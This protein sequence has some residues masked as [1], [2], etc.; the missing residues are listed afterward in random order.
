MEAS[1]E[2]RGRRYLTR[3]LLQGCPA[4]L[5]IASLLGCGGVVGSGPS[6]PPPLTISVSPSSASILLGEAQLFTATLNNATTSGVTWSVNGIAGGNPAVGTIDATGLYTAP[7]A[8]LASGA[9]TVQAASVDDPSKTASASVKITSDVSVSISPATSSVE[10]GAS[11]AFS[12]TV[13]SMGK[14]NPSF[15]W[16]V[17]ET[18]CTG[19]SCGIVDANGTYTAPQILPAVTSITLTATSI[20]DP[21]K[22]AT[23]SINLTSS[24]TLNLS[25][26]LTVFTRTVVNY[27]AVVTPAAN[28][29]PSRAVA[30]S[31]SGAGCTGAACGTISASGAYSAP[32]TPPA[33]ATVQITATPAAD[34]SKAV[35][36]SATIIASLTVSVTPTSATLVLGG[37][38]A[39][40]AQVTGASDTT[41]TWDVNGVV[42]GNSL[43]GTIL[44]S[45]TDPNNTTYTAPVALPPGS[46]VTVRASSNANPNISAYAIVTLTTGISVTLAP[47]IS[48]RVSGQRQTFTARANFTSNQNFAWTVGGVPGGNTAVGQIC[49]TGSDP[50]H[51]VTIGGGSIDY[52]APAGIPFPNPVSITA[53]SQADGNTS[54]SASVTILPHLVLNVLPGSVTV[55]NGAQQPF[56]ATVVGASNQQ[57]LWN[58]TGSACGVSGACGS[59]DSLGMYTAP[60]FAPSPNRINVVATSSADT[61]QTAAATVTI[62]TGP[63]IASLAPSSAAAG[64]AGGFTLAI[65]GSNFAPSNPGPGSIMLVAGT[66]GTT[67][68]ASS[69]VC[70]TSL[71]A[72]DLQSAGSFSVWA[73]NPGGAISNIAS[74]VVLAAGS[75]SGAI[76]LTPGAPSATGKNIV[77]ADLSTN[78]GSNASGNVGLDIG[79]IGVY[80]VF[81]NSCALADS[82]VILVRPPSGVASADLC[83]FS[84]SGLDPS[85]TYSVSGPT[86]PDITIVNREPLGFGIL[87]LTLQIPANSAAGARTL[88]VQ[89]PAKDMAA[90]SGILEVR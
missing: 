88:F 22:S 24:F 87:H 50:C 43:V 62:S 45:Q 71:S 69:S 17:S 14:P 64:S 65:A 44:N 61:S 7:G 35:T 74:F 73:Q 85:F 39:F 13:T 56:T 90:G 83:V 31:V 33:P 9:V 11:F 18:G 59:I 75:A 5:L 32:D 29:N 70:T 57:V 4:I 77:V 41:V 28:S 58:V 23:A 10:L 86:V 34:H 40:Q 19:A 54:S 38:Q 16:V 68:C 84:V 20:A 12:G 55:P 3:K 47:P 15:T 6:Q 78:G 36:V 8:L 27:T 21:S 26:P 66:P 67:I 79:A 52:L 82:P 53:T 76:P 49:A 2:Y 42:G 48:T 80:S 25:G 51:P 60:A 89:N 37:T 30:W 63:F 1:A 81:S 72:A 46:T